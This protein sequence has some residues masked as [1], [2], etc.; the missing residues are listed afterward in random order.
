MSVVLV[1]ARGVQLAVVQLVEEEEEEEATLTILRM[2]VDLFFH[3]E[4]VSF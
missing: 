1:L 4:S 2:T 3:C